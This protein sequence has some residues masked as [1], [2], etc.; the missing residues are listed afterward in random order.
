[1]FKSF[2]ITSNDKQI[3]CIYKNDFN[4]Q[5]KDLEFPFLGM[6]LSGGHT[7][8]LLC[9]GINDMELLGSTYDDAIGECYDKVARLLS[10]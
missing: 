1:M 9:K 3:F 2:R 4:L 7:L 5:N 8:L 10:I 6:V